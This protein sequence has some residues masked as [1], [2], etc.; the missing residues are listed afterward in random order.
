ME[1]LTAKEL[2]SALKVSLAAV[3]AWTRQGI[4]YVPCGRLRRFVLGE[5]LAWLRERETQRRGGAGEVAGCS[6]N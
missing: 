1:L 3:R 4:P 6:A 2:A 5:V